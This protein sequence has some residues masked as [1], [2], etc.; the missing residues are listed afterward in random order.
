LRLT[1]TRAEIRHEVTAIAPFDALEAAHRSD[2]H[3]D[4]S[5]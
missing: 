4:G 5:W 1:M 3:L 2:P